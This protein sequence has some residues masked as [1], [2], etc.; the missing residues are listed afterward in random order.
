M[1]I[2]QCGGENWSEEGCPDANPALRAGNCCHRGDHGSRLQAARQSH[3]GCIDVSGHGAPDLS[4]LGI[5]LR[6]G[7]GSGSHGGL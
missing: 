3:N 1:S 7:A 2:V 4:L 5:A 6:G